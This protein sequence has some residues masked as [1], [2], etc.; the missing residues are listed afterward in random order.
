M[1]SQKHV[2]LCKCITYFVYFCIFYLFIYSFNDHIFRVLFQEFV[3][4]D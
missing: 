3:E 2:L 1:K 4:Q